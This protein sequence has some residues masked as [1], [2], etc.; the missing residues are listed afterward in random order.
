MISGL[1]K[2]SETVSYFSPGHSGVFESNCR[3]LE[4]L[5]QYL[6]A[7][8][9]NKFTVLLRNNAENFSQVPCTYHT[10]GM[11]LIFEHF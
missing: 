4:C 6:C 7:V 11:E 10:G 1:G 5:A 2:H 3:K 9:E 8:D